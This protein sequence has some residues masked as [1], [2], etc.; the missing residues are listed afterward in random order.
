MNGYET[1]Y[2]NADSVRE[3]VNDLAERRELP[4][5]GNENGISS[6]LEQFKRSVEVDMRY[7]EP[8]EVDDIRTT[9]KKIQLIYYQYHR[10]QK[11]YDSKL[12]ILVI[13]YL[14]PDQQGS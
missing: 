12:L 13:I 9:R 14:N 11:T 6:K 3:V 7:P 10:I 1:T 8:I 5:E 4:D 2:E